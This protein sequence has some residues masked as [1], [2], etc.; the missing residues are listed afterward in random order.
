MVYLQNRTGCHRRILNHVTAKGVISARM[1]ILGGF[2]MLRSKITT[3]IINVE[4][5]FD[6]VDVLMN[7]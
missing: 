1:G 2:A 3:C 4:S 5:G 7:E 6:D